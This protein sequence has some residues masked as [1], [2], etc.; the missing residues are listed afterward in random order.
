MSRWFPVTAVALRAHEP[1]RQTL[2][3]EA[4]IR[5]S[6]TAE[7]IRT[8]ELRYKPYPMSG[9]RESEP[10]QPPTLHDTLLGVVGPVCRRGMRHRAGPR[11]EGQ[12]RGARVGRDAQ[13]VS[14]RVGAPDPIRV[15]SEAH[16]LVESDR[17]LVQ[18]PGPPCDQARELQVDGRPSREDSGIHRLFQPNYGQ[19]V[20]MDVH[21]E[22]AERVKPGS[23]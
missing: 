17:D 18:H 5:L 7:A 3:T 11:E 14:D 4:S 20:Q 9:R 15:C 19:A 2:P 22:A 6:V 1:R 10:R 21:R 12:V 16:V 23:E 8:H 13:G